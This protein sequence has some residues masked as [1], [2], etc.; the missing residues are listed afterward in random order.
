M[1]SFANTEKTLINTMAWNYPGYCGEPPRY[2]YYPEP[3]FVRD[4]LR[5]PRYDPAAPMTFR[6]PPFYEDGFL[7]DVRRHAPDLG[8]P[9]L[10]PREQVPAPLIL[11]SPPRGQAPLI[12]SRLFP[13]KNLD[14]IRSEMQCVSLVVGLCSREV[15]FRR[16]NGVH[17]KQLE[18]TH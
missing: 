3:A 10:V 5:L 11:S 1:I 13:E 14:S 18:F 9:G 2:V 7:R 12:C 8:H 6:Q 15:L 16:A 4:E 17:G